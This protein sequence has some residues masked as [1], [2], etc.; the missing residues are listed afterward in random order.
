MY[1]LYIWEYTY[2]WIYH[3]DVYTKVTTVCFISGQRILKSDFDYSLFIN[4]G[5]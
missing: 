1:T 2:I 3:R 4:L 5:C